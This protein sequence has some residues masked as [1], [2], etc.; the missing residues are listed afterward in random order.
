MDNDTLDMLA[1]LVRQEDQYYLCPEYPSSCSRR[2][3]GS[4]QQQQDKLVT[5][6][7]EFAHV[8]TDQQFVVAAAVAPTHTTT[9]TSSDMDVIKNSLSSTSLNDIQ[10]IDQMQQQNH[11]TDS[12][13]FWRHQMYNW[14]CMVTDSFT[15]DREI[16]QSSLNVLDR[17]VAHELKQPDSP[18]ITRDD[19]QLFA[20]TTFYVAVKVLEPYPRKIGL[21]TLVDMSRGFYSDHDICMTE[22]D[23]LSALGWHVNPPTA[24]TFSRLFC[25]LFPGNVSTRMQS[26]A[27]ALTDIA[28]SDCSLVSI[29]AA[30][31]GLASV[32][33]AARLD[34]VA[35]HVVKSFLASIETVIS[36][37]GNPEFDLVYGRLDQA[38]ASQ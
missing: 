36:T 15:M 17:F 16:V 28:V 21:Q 37:Q 4:T 38:Y 24:V 11:E 30:N 1:A 32:L 31:M 35:E 18:A 3:H 33:L 8:V 10:N 27:L 19:Y 6:L 23:L 29:K 22:Q 20:M 2:Q 5:M 12:F 14:A 9:P 26:A 25:K 34:G 13:S 7:H